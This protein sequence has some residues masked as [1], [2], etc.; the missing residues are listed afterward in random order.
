METGRKAD[1]SY[2]FNNVTTLLDVVITNPASPTNRE[3]LRTHVVEGAAN[4][5][6]EAR[7]RDRY[8]DV[9]GMIVE[10]DAVNFVPLAVEATGR[11]GI[12]ALKFLD[13]WAI[14]PLKVHARHALGSISM[15]CNYY[16]G[17]MTLC[18]LRKSQQAHLDVAV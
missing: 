12:D 8:R 13:S 15:L 17:H 6:A 1:I 16:S 4:L 5:G 7:K 10:G 9:P 2:V 3:T 11:L 14:G 18:L